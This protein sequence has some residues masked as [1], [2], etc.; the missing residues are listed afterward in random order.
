MWF[1]YTSNSTTTSISFNRVEF[2]IG[3][4]TDKEAQAI[5]EDIYKFTMD[6]NPIR[7]QNDAYKQGRWKNS[8]GYFTVFYVEG[9]DTD[10]L[11][12]LFFKI[13]LRHPEFT[14]VPPRTDGVMR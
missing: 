11:K 9:E 13:K 6:T 12:R 10:R 1:K 5:F 4:A 7:G 3:D 2:T 8:L 14:L